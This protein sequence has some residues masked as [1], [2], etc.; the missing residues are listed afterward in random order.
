MRVGTQDRQGQDRRN[1]SGADR[2]NPT[3]HSLLLPSQQL[4]AVLAV[5][6]RGHRID[7]GGGEEVRRVHDL[8]RVARRQHLAQ[9]RA[10]PVVHVIAVKGYSPKRRPHC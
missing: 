9:N 2:R 5:L 4:P 6:P 7:E 10:N 1:G 8:R 3:G